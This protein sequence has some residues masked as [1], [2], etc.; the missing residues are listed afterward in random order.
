MI[1]NDLLNNN[2][3]KLIFLQAILL[4]IYYGNSSKSTYYENII[5]KEINNIYVN[6]NKKYEDI[7]NNLENKKKNIINTIKILNNNNYNYTKINYLKNNIIFIDKEINKNKI[8]L[9]KDKNL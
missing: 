2:E 6:H 8:I 9:N 1:I 4:G 7:I 5:N 3:Y